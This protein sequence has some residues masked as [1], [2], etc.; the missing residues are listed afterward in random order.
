MLGTAIAVG[1]DPRNVFTMTNGRILEI[2]EKSAKLTGT[3]PF[4]RILY[5]TL[6]FSEIN[7]IL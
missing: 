6:A 5:I 1:V 7:D 2:T 3:V 4:G